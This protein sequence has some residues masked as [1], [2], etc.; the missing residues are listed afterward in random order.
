MR[1]RMAWTLAAVTAVLAVADVFV[2]AAYQSLFSETAVAQHGFP[3]VDLA[4]LGSAVLGALIISRSE[5]HPVG[6]LLILVGVTGAFSLLA[7]SYSIWV[8]S[9]GGPGSRSL[10]GVAGWLSTLLGGQLALAGLA[11][12]FLLAPDGQFLSR[13]WR[14]AGWC[15]AVGELCSVTAV[16]SMN[17]ARFDLN[18]QVNFVRGLLFTIG[19]LM[20]TI[21]LLAAV[22]SMI[23]RLRRSSG[24]ERQQLRLIALGVVL[25][26]VGVV[27]LFVVQGINGGRQTWLSSLPLLISYVL[28]PVF[29]TV[30]IL[31]YRLYDVEV[32]INWTVVLAV[33]AAFA[34]VGYTTLVV[35]VGRLVDS[36]TSGFWVSLLA[37][38]LV[39]L[40]FQPLRR[41]VIR[42]ANRLAY[43]SRAQPYEAL[44]DFSR[45]LAETPSPATLLSA[46]AEAAGRAV[47]ARHATAAL[48]G[49]GTGEVAASW[50][51]PL[52]EA[53]SSYAVPVQNEGHVLGSIVVGIDRNRP[54]RPSDERL[55]TALADQAAVAFRNTA[56]ET[57]LAAQVAELDR[58]THELSES[59]SRIIDAEDAA[60]RTLETAVSRDVL[61]HLVSLPDELRRAREAVSQRAAANG[62]DV[63]VADTTSALESLRELTRGIFPTQLARAGVEPAL[64]SLVARSKPPAALDVH[65]NVAGRRFSAR[66]EAAVYFC[67]AEAARTGITSIELV[68]AGPELLLHVGRDDTSAVDL[69]PLVDRVEAAGG[70]LVAGAGDLRCVIPVGTD[71]PATQLLVSA[72]VGG[73]GDR[74]GG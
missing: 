66:V 19:F 23:V 30:A 45:R 15:L 41:A 58:T 12:M 65:P 60:R 73:G 43:G 13:R 47:A 48:L 69:Q 64:R 56:M 7:E 68:L 54:W 10:G 51:E 9:G 25:V 62:L 67:C 72:A 11:L 31:R 8:I 44:S 22:A 50:G 5:R 29:F 57:S 49:S 32:I 71:G 2:A 55:L 4:V 33:G 37:T 24:V 28:M 1:A 38:S 27:N 70:S 39:A 6:V 74:P 34:A 16:L 59:R 18:M 63:L 52:T 61:P 17:P 46:V 14:A 40:A 3:F 21:G 36:R 53:M 42:F 35:L 26:A 20:V